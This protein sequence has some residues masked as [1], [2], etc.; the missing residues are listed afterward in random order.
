LA[1]VSKPELANTPPAPKAPGPP[2]P[3]VAR[4][5]MAEGYIWHEETRSWILRES[6]KNMQSGHEAKDATM[7]HG[8]SVHGVNPGAI[9]GKPYKPFALNEDG[10]TSDNHF[11]VSHAGVHKVGA[12]LDKPP[13]A[14]SHQHTTEASLG[15]A[16]KDTKVGAN[17][18][19][20]MPGALGAG[21]VLANSG[22]D[23]AANH[24]T[25]QPESKGV[26][27]SVMDSLKGGAMDKLKDIIGLDE[28]EDE[29]ALDRLLVKYK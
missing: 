21:G 2:D 12:A 4:R 8:G 22:L 27:G 9:V 14:S 20:H 19:V 11:V 7:I 16:L 29:S 1:A 26:I 6:M 24:I 17:G 28:V 15:H 23:T 13:G 25:Q 5:K 10:S 3:E 18:A